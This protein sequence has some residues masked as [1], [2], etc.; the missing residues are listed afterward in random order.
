MSTTSRQATMSAEFTAGTLSSHVT[1]DDAE[2]GDGNGLVTGL[3]H[4]T[5]RK[6]RHRWSAVTSL[7][8]AASFLQTPL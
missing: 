7:V 4:W 2:R 8:P 3:G 5:G 1:E 6:R